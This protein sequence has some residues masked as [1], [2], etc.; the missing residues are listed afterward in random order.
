V[1]EEWKGFEK[2]KII[3]KFLSKDDIFFKIL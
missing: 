1:N 3:E 2:K